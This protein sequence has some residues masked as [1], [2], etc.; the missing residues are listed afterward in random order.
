[1]NVT[2]DESSDDVKEV[3]SYEA[4]PSIDPFFW[5]LTVCKFRLTEGT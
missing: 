1:M 5:K 3:P 2:L 4:E